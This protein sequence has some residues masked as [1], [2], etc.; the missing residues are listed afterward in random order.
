MQDARL[1][2]LMNSMCKAHDVLGAA[3][4]HLQ[5]LEGLAKNKHA[6]RERSCLDIPGCLDQAPQLPF[7]CLPILHMHS[8]CACQLEGQRA[9][10]INGLLNC[11]RW[12]AQLHNMNPF[13]G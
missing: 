2:K 5:T 6:S 9:M 12:Q 4:V 13:P 11:N 8:A 3:M 1:G 10:I 7:R